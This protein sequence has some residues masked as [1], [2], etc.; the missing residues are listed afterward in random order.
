MHAATGPRSD[1]S[2][3]SVTHNIIIFSDILFAFN[4][5]PADHDYCR[6]TI[7]SIGRPNHCYWG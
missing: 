3:T 4:P 6:F 2:F 1:E 7:C 5:N